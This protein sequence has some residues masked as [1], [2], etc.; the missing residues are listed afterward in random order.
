VIAFDGRTEN[1]ENTTKRAEGVGQSKISWLDF[2]F[3]SQK[4]YQESEY[5][6]KLTSRFASLSILIIKVQGRS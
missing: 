4:R 5:G 1:L 2:D 3:V 6:Q